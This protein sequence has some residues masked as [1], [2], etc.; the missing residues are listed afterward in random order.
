M[1]VTI[2][3][4]A[5]THRESGKVYVGKTR[6]TMRRRWMQHLAA[7]RLGSPFLFHSAIRKHGAEAFDHQVLEQVRSEE[8]G[9]E[10]EKRWISTFRSNDTKL[11]YNLNAGGGGVPNTSPDLKR[12]RSA[13]ARAR[14]AAMTQEQKTARAMRGLAGLPPEE[15]MARVRQFQKPRTKAEPKQRV[16]LTAEQRLEAVRMREARKTPE[17]RSAAVRKG[18]AKRT[19]EARAA[20]AKRLADSNRKKRCSSRAGDAS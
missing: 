15:R 1:T 9:N 2:T 14:E 11:G 18:H 7:V 6:Q 8:S 17:Q 5:H 20:A 3:I 19:P 10:A 16:L 13:A 4:Y 12:R